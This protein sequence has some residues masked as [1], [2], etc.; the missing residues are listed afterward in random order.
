MPRVS[1][2]N[3]TGKSLTDT[4]PYIFQPNVIDKHRSLYFP[5]YCTGRGK[6]GRLEAQWRARAN[7]EEREAVA[8][9]RQ[10]ANLDLELQISKAEQVGPIRAIYYRELVLEDYYQTALQY[11]RFADTSFFCSEGRKRDPKEW[12]TYDRY[13]AKMLSSLGLNWWNVEQIILEEFRRPVPKKFTKAVGDRKDLVSFWQM[14]WTDRMSACQLSVGTRYQT[15][16]VEEIA[17][18]VH[19]TGRLEAIA[20]GELTSF[21]VD[22]DEIMTP[23]GKVEFV[24]ATEEEQLILEAMHHHYPIMPLNHIGETE[25]LHGS[26]LYE[27][28]IKKMQSENFLLSEADDNDELFVKYKTAQRSPF[29]NRI[30]FNL[31]IHLW[32]NLDV[33]RR[34]ATGLAR[35]I[36]ERKEA[37]LQM[38]KGL[39]GL[40]RYLPEEFYMLLTD[41]L[42]HLPVVQG[43]PDSHEIKDAIRPKEEANISLPNWDGLTADNV[44]QRFGTEYAKFRR[45]NVANSIILKTCDH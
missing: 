22:F 8:Q 35:H 32:R 11:S 6:V 27:L 39:G 2:P 4:P 38:G 26:L 12:L 28:C 40:N 42:Y 10:E 24:G 25:P 20:S 36:L 43:L 7:R 1:T 37:W 29:I 14:A 9:R 23:E 15:K 13:L 44:R 21:I 31:G 16:Q 30:I 3:F 19:S 33:T 18:K 34:P 17:E 41:I 45:Q 5:F